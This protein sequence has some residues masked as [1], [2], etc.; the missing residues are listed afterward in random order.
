MT[1]KKKNKKEHKIIKK[2]VTDRQSLKIP[3]K[4]IGWK[5][6]SN[7][8]LHLDHLTVWLYHIF[9]MLTKF[10]WYLGTCD[11]NVSVRIRTNLICKFIKPHFND[12]VR[13]LSERTKIKKIAFR[14]LSNLYQFSRIFLYLSN[15]WY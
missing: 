7:M 3:K 11:D 14:V 15:S 8:G 9:N 13:R 2:S 5:M 4:R 12:R 10:S 6:W 1:K